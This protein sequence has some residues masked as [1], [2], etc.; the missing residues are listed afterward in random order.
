MMGFASSRFLTLHPF[1]HEVGR[2]GK[3][4]HQISE[5]GGSEYMPRLPVPGPVVIPNTIQIAM[6]WAEAGRSFKNILHGTAP[7]TGAL[8]P[9]LANTLHTAFATALTSSGL[10][11]HLAAA[12][13]FSQVSIKDL[14]TANL[15]EHFSTGAPV[16]GSGTGTALPM[17]CCA[18][19]TLRTAQAGKAFRGRVYIGGL[20]ETAVSDPRTI[21]GGTDSAL[22]A[23]VDGVRAAMTSNG[24]P[25]VIAQRAL[26]AGTSASGGTLPARAASS[27]PV[28]SV[29]IAN[30]RVDSQR[31]RLG[32]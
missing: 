4:L 30:P 31:R 2:S 1:V 15:S 22:V 24:V 13:Q 21:A 28:V 23:F 3:T 20:D 11:P 12:L 29:D 17:N 9:A 18:V 8:D 16:A 6:H 14:R 26:Q 7:T 5:T 10:L 32:R 25:M 19:V 27:V